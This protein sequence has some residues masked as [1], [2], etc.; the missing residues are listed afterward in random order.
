MRRP[1][2]CALHTLYYSRLVHQLV[3]LLLPLTVLL[4]CRDPSKRLLLLRRREQLKKW[5][6]ST[7][8]LV[9]TKRNLFACVTR[10]E[11][12]SIH[13]VEAI[14]R[15]LRLPCSHLELLAD[16]YSYFGTYREVL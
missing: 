13:W 15:F 10:R 6:Y 9:R 16:L 4:M 1:K 3:V 2:R 5:L 11:V 14:W 8:V 12:N 7:Y